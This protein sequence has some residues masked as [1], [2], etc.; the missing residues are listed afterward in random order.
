MEQISAMTAMVPS[1]VESV[2][3]SFCKGASNS[4]TH[5]FANIA[6]LCF[7]R[8][9]GATFLNGRFEAVVVRVIPSLSFPFFIVIMV[10]PG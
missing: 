8:L 7:M 6:F 2:D 9:M 1:I 3:L 4:L 5:V 10:A